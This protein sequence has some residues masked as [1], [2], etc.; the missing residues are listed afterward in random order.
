MSKKNETLKLD[1]NYQPNKPEQLKIGIIV[2]HW[3]SNV[4]DLLSKACIDTLLKNGVNEDNIRKIEVPGAFELPLAA[5]ILL[6]SEKIDAIVCLGCVIK[7]ETNHDEYINQSVATGITQLALTSSKP[8]IFGVLTVLNEQQAIDRANG[9]HGNKGA[10][11]AISAL[12]MISIKQNFNEPK[13]KIG[14]S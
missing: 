8:I 14:F 4:T 9:S 2:S 6:T 12:H 11:C 10:E 5:R 1:K 13:S 3:N 7:G